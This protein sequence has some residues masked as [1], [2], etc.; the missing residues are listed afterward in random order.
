MRIFIGVDKRQQVAYTVCRSS[1]ER[2]A[3]KRVSVEPIRIEWTPVTRRGLTDFT[4]ARYLVPW[5]S[6]FEGI[7]VFM[8]ADVIVR[9]DVNELAERAGEHPVS[10][11]KGP[12]KFEW[13]SVMVFNNTLC[14]VLSPEFINDPKNQ[15]QTLE[16]ASEIG[17]LPS[18]WNHCVG[19][20]KPRRDAKL[21]HF[22]AG[23]PCF[24]ETEGCEY[25]KE[26]NQE[27][28]YANSTVAWEDLMGR[29]V[30]AEMVRS[31]HLQK[32]GYLHG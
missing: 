28:E 8:D 23:I 7:S 13:P 18:E 6:G 29:S 19:Y 1:V 10:V 21:I 3:K 25:T 26:W 4:F 12:L 2:Y 27:L 15:P 16:W 5:L 32:R 20:D 31:G 14:D 9:G 24:P 17:E 30:H 22:T 11:R